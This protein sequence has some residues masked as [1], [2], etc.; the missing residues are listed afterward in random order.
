MSG[1]HDTAAHSQA[2]V[3]SKAIVRSAHAAA[4]TGIAILRLLEDGRDAL[5][6]TASTDQR[7]KT[8][9]LVGW[10]SQDLRI[11]LLDDRYSAVA[12]SGDLE[13][14][15]RDRVLVVGVGMEV[16]RVP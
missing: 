8:W 5:V 2:R 13:V 7:V 6:V 16:W 9:R 15:D 11:V 1:A 12:D 14:L 4:V 3:Q 10:Q